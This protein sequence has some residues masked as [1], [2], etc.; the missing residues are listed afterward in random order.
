M[1]NI[2]ALYIVEEPK[3]GGPQVQMARVAAA[4]SRHVEV[5]LLIPDGDNALFCRLS[6]KLGINYDVVRLSGLTRQLGPLARFILRTPVEIADLVRKIR[7]EKPDI[8][9]AWGGAWQF[10]AAVASRVTGVPLVWLLNDT[11]SPTYIRWIFQL[12]AKQG[13]AFIFA[14]QKTA[15]YYSN[16]LPARALRQIVQSMVDLDDFDPSGSYQGDEEL[17]ASWGDDFVV[18]VIANISPVKG[19]E[20]FVRVAARAA[21]A[22]RNCQ[23]VIVGQTYER[24]EKLRDSLLDLAVELGAD[25]LH[26]VGARKDVRPLLQRFDAYLCSSVNESSP[27]AVWEAMAMGCPVVSTCVGDVPHFVTD[28]STGFVAPVGDDAALWRDL[29]S[30]IANPQNRVSIGIAARKTAGQA[31][32]RAAIMCKTLEFYQLVLSKR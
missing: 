1:S 15:D 7:E 2:K 27:V 4:L 20:T 12:F 13:S 24:Q 31:F 10:K 23:F 6:E 19:L 28:G 29:E 32:G 16:L 17:I 9:H 3:L 25:N 26:F 30:L 14:S 18:G 21:A 22:Q 8:L 5:K 11:S